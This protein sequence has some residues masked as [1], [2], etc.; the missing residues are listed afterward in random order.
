[1]RIE[2]I[3]QLL[4]EQPETYT[5]FELAGMGIDPK[6]FLFTSRP[7]FTDN[8]Y[9]LW[10]FIKEKTDCRTAWLVSDEEVCAVLRTRGIRCELSNTAQ[11]VE[12][13][14]KARFFIGTTINFHSAYV[15]RPGQVYVNLWH[16]SGV[17]GHYFSDRN[18]DV[19]PFYQVKKDSQLTDLFLVQ[20]MLDKFILASLLY[21]DTRKMIATGQARIDCTR[22]AAGK[23]NLDRIF[24]NICSTYSKLIFFAPTSKRTNISVAGSYYSENVFGLP[25][26]DGD[27]MNELLEKHN[28][29][30]VLKLHPIEEEN[31]KP[32][33][34]TW[35][36][37]C[38]VLNS[39]ALFH[40]DLHT[41]DIMNAFDMMIADY[42]SMAY[43]FLIL[44]RPIVYNIPEK[45][46]YA[47]KQ[48]FV[49]HNVD[50]WMPGEKVFTFDAL[51]CA[52]DEALIDPSKYQKERQDII[53]LRYDH[54]DD[55]AAQR[56]YEEMI[57]YRPIVDYGEK[58]FTQE[59]LLPMAEA[60]EAELSSLKASGMLRDKTELQ[61][62]VSA[63]GHYE[64]QLSETETLIHEYEG[65]IVFIAPSFSDNTGYTR[66][67]LQHITQ[68][69]GNKGYLVLHGVQRHDELQS[70]IYC[71][72]KGL[73]QIPLPILL[74]EIMG[75]LD[76]CGKKTILLASQ[77]DSIISLK[78]MKALC[79]RA[80]R[81]FYFQDDVPADHYTGI[82]A[83]ERR[84]LF[85]F[86][87]NHESAHIIT[88][89]QAVYQA[90]FNHRGDRR[91]HLITNGVDN[92]F[93][94][95]NSH[96]IPAPIQDIKAKNKPVIGY[97]G[98]VG[99]NIYLSLVQYLCDRFK[100]YN[101]VLVGKNTLPDDRQL[102]L[103]T[104]PNLIHI[105]EI[106]YDEIPGTINS[107]DVAILPYYKGM[108]HKIPKELFEYLACGRIVVASDMPGIT[109]Y[110]TVFTSDSHGEFVRQIEKAMTLKDDPE[111]IKAAKETARHNDWSKKAEAL[112]NLIGGD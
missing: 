56:A 45:E 40:A 80:Y 71:S 60:Y 48:G 108:L 3:K 20:N 23:A 6:L 77:G 26:F 94:D 29:A 57:G 15:K 61:N 28:A 8:S 4:N 53:A 84:K 69:L 30:V 82:N 78:D 16:G 70:G 46:E 54:N 63:P 79:D 104:Y 111:I 96:N 51:C 75:I 1:M 103:M 39:R 65:D 17:K 14:Q 89:D 21:C 44:D 5:E 47:Q 68:K 67:R 93:F 72:A 22:E 38:Y 109:E 12:L 41:N 102:F 76:A 10:K 27:R 34:L 92:A 58:Y 25:D 42:T 13:V 95:E 31:F 85:Q 66:S 81:I 36:K 73:F 50:F 107:F 98:I 101:I 105:D 52:I 7:D 99:N 11:A 24:D 18:N 110:S 90:V 49:Y 33:D 55:S 100:E 35:G 112:L 83:D 64:K 91:L 37:H 97:C 106:P 62:N 86:I 43:D 9:A 87:V 2:Q 19:Q 32:H 59:M 88:P 74:D